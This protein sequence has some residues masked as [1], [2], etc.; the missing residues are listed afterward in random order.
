MA[1]R[2]NIPDRVLEDTAACLKILAHP[3]R[4]RIVEILE[5]EDLTVG[6]LAER[7]GL[8]QAAVSQHLN[9]MKARGLLIS[10]RQGR[11]VH[12]RVLHPQCSQILSCI[13][14]NLRNKKKTRKR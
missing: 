14:S 10:Q 1:H 5:K 4:L 7:L 8:P 3:L 13:R 9:L 11:S 2:T 6:L 12:Y